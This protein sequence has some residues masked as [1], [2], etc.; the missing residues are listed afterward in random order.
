M[1]EKIVELIVKLEALA[2]HVWSLAVRQ[3]WVQAVREL[4][5][6]LLL[7]AAGIV[8]GILG[9]RRGKR[10]EGKALGDP[11][12]WYFFSLVV[13]LVPVVIG[14]CLLYSSVGKLMNPG[15]YAVKLLVGLLP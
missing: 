6:G 7:T 12:T 8:V 3:V 10:E 1:E 14:G 13:G 11:W 15:W 9:F 5:A 4:V 2:P